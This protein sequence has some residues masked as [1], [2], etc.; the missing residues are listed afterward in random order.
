[1]TAND[2]CP[3]PELFARLIAGQ[4]N[5]E[6]E[7]RLISH[8]DHCSRCQ[9]LME[10]D[11]PPELDA[12]LSELSQRTGDSPVVQQAVQNVKA[13]FGQT[14]DGVPTSANESAAVNW[15]ENGYEP[16]R[17]LGRGGMGVVFLAR[18]KSLA[19]FVAIKFLSPE[20]AQNEKANA[21]FIRE[22]RAAA[23]IKHPSVITIHAVSDRPPLPYL[24]MEYVDG[25]SLQELVDQRGHL[26]PKEVIRIAGQIT[27]GLAKAHA[28]GIIH[29]DIKPANILIESETGRAKLTDFGL[30]QLTGQSH[31]TQSGVIVGTPAYVA[32]EVLDESSPHDQRSD[33]FSLGGVMYAM[34]CGSSP[35]ES[36]SIVQTLHK[37]VSKDPPPIR[38]K[39]NSVPAWLDSVIAKLLHKDPRE[40]YQSSQQLLD[41][42]RNGGTKTA[43]IPAKS[44]MP[45]IET[46]KSVRRSRSGKRK[47]NSPMPWIIATA[48]VMLA[49]VATYFAIAGNTN[50]SN[51]DERVAAVAAA[52][53]ET[54]GDQTSRE[55][56][57]SPRDNRPTLPSL[58]KPTVPTMLGTAGDNKF[59]VMRGE[60][61]T[62][63]YDRFEDAVE[64]ADDDCTIEIKTN[65]P[66]T[67]AEMRL[68]QTG[69]TIK[70][71]DGFLPTIAFEPSDEIEEDA[72]LEVEGDLA[73]IG[74]KLTAGL[75]D[76]DED[77][78]VILVRIEGGTFNATDC[79]F[80]S[81]HGTCVENEGMKATTIENCRFHSAYG[82]GINLA[83]SAKGVFHLENSSLSAETALS[84]EP[85]MDMTVDI[86]HC[87]LVA[88]ECL[89]L[90]LEDAPAELLDDNRIRLTVSDCVLV[91]RLAAYCLD[92]DEGSQE[93]FRQLVLFRGSNNLYSGPFLSR[94]IDQ[95]TWFNDLAA[96]NRFAR[97]DE[98]TSAANPFQRSMSSVWEN[99]DDLLF[100]PNELS[101]RYSLTESQRRIINSAGSRS[102]NANDR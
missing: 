52:S 44:P 94:S 61:P 10:Q 49:A 71:A 91:S 54:T 86:D 66:I 69:L 90:V 102:P 77:R 28:A 57:A 18:E 6:S 50:D 101:A 81:L 84:I 37:I 8:I 80:R 16:I 3:P 89:S 60:I 43:E 83:A 25:L 27:Q 92:G 33:L 48:G 4:L 96:W 95:R 15:Q 75:Q 19:R 46:V 63:S 22:A 68:E 24:V 11:V 74:L 87:R 23:S 41:A 51:D 100:D 73:L 20:Y 39:V 34:C 56:S 17:Q 14:M 12:Q 5:P 21:R 62:G 55:R 97:E 30:A 42:L 7:S 32:P 13:I 38:E 29:R 35:F 47:K 72:M 79:V 9:Q 36:D 93:T 64:E 1:M 85:S 45:R 88:T 67:I 59:V 99:R 70:A 65:G 26:N 40:R 76:I 2:H 82:T 98:T 53:D 31:L 78:A 58:K